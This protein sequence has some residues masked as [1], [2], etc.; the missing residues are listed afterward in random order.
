MHT[1]LRAVRLLT[2]VLW[3][4]GLLF[5]AFVVAP[6]AFSILPSKHLAGL[7][8]AGTLNILHYIGIASGG[9]FLAATILLPGKRRNLQIALIVAMLAVTAYLQFSLIPAMER[10]R[11]QSGGDIDAAPAT[12]PARIDFERLHPLSEK[13]EGI[14]LFA[15]L[16]VVLLM[17]AEPKA[18]DS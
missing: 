13:V 4:G 11:I 5:F 16:A 6:I 18:I 15:G 7:V 8:V 17:A 1:T 9:L 2:I 14:V 10:D 12:D 3:E